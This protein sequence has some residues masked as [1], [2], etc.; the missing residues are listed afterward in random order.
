[1]DLWEVV[2]RESVRDLTA[3]YNAHGDAGRLDELLEVFTLDA[4]IDMEGDV[5]SGR[6]EMRT[7][8]Q[9]AGREFVAY[10]RAGGTPRNGPVLRHCLTTQHIDV[11]SED[12]VHAMTYFVVFMSHGLDHWGTYRDS[13]VR[14]DGSWYV[15]ARQV[16]VDGAIEGGFADTRLKR[17]R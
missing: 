7:A 13:F 11:R 17:A 16:V 6:D 5:S 2:A 3:R 4:T 8:F 1:M 12:E 15:K 9:A 14:V 10:A